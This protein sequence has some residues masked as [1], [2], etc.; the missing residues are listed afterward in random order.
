MS[1][2]TT[3]SE[4]STGSRL[5]IRVTRPVGSGPRLRREEADRERLLEPWTGHLVG[6][7]LAECEAECDVD[8]VDSGRV[9]HEVGHL[10]ARDP[11]RDLDDRHRPV[12]VGDQLRKGD[13]VAEAEHL[14]GPC[15]NVLRALQLVA[16][17]GGRIDVDPADPEADPGRSEPVGERHDLGHALARDHDPVHLR[18]LDEALEDAL[19]ARRF[20]E[21]GV[22]V[23]LE[24]A[25][26]LDP[27]DAALPAGVGRLEDGGQADR[28]DCPAALYE[29]PHRGERRLRDPVFGE[30][31]PHHDL[32][33]HPLRDRGP[34]R[35]QPE[36]LGHLRDNGYGAVCGDRQRAVDGV[37][38][39]DLRDGVDV[40]EVDRLR[41]VRDLQPERLRVA[42][43]SDHAKALL[44][45]LH[46]RAPLVAPRADEEDGLHRGDASDPTSYGR[47]GLR[48]L[49]EEEGDAVPARDRAAVDAAQPRPDRAAVVDAGHERCLRAAE[50][51]RARL[52]LRARPCKCPVPDRDQL[53]ARG[54]RRGDAAV[55][56]RRA[57]QL[58]PLR[59]RRF[60]RAVGDA[61]VD[62]AGRAPR[63][64]RAAAAARNG[65]EEGEP[66]H[67]RS[68]DR[69]R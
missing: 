11:R 61:E 1:A 68:Q 54:R 58:Q 27:E 37:P 63:R 44:P 31:A 36:A 51:L 10:P 55:R 24:V 53:A 26:A 34:D 69:R 59:R 30:G 9:T 5:P 50:D 8:E 52:R 65:D 41:D 35:R 28:P 40:G 45:R 62:R 12:G 49:R 21:R 25:F 56:G 17:D 33:P 38:P 23:A 20:G 39:R 43:D 13:P 3:P 64:G 16:V 2:C 32:V 67:G 14:D 15:G 46:D 6:H 42:V 47:R 22:E 66:V 18:S 19:L 29:R 60:V 48:R 4:A 57:V 7:G